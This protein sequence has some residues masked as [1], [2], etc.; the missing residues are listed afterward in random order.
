MQNTPKE[1]TRF[2]F[3]YRRMIGNPFFIVSN[4][5]GERLILD[6]LPAFF[7]KKFIKNKLLE[8]YPFLKEHEDKIEIK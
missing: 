1:K 5:F 3:E 8:E 2:Q 4:N 7:R 6:K